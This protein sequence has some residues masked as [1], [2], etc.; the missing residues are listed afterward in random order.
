VFS[1]YF[2]KLV[3]QLIESGINIS[4]LM[5]CLSGQH[6]M[7][8]DFSGFRNFFTL[9]FITKPI[10]NAHLMTSKMGDLLVQ[11]KMDNE[12]VYAVSTKDE[13]GNYSTLLTYCSKHFEEDLPEILEVV[14]ELAADLN[15]P[16]DPESAKDLPF[17]DPVPVKKNEGLTT[18]GQVQFVCCAGRYAAPERP[19]TGAFRVLRVL[20]G[21][22]YLW[23]RIRVEGGAYGCMSSFTRE[24]NAFLV[25]YRDPHL[26]RTIEVFKK[27]SEFLRTFDADERTMTKYIIGAISGLDQPMTPFVYGR[28]SLTALLGGITDE[29]L[30]KERDQVLDA[31]PADIRALADYLDA[32]LSFDALCVVGSDAKLRENAEL[33]KDIRKLV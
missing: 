25:S 28:F 26:R 15:P 10:Y 1:A 6:E 30:Q 13:Q 27:T 11:S 22:E 9:N 14:Q 12:H 7:V 33:F 17:F 21:Y 32:I 8:T 3:Y 5:I 31:T 23:S 2:A 29:M 16:L 4:K 24:G 19:C 18:A 20:L